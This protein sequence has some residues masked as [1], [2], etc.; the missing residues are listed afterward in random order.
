MSDNN[1][2]FL[3]MCKEAQDELASGDKGWKEADTNTLLMAAFGMLFNHLTSK[4]VRPLWFAA[5]AIA[6]GAI[7]YLVKLFM[8]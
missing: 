5:G 7:G 4:I 6:T 3:R 8:N 2:F 1:G